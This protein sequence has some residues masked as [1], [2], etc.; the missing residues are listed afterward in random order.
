MLQHVPLLSS[1]REVL[2]FSGQVNR[3][4]RS[5]VSFSLAL[6]LFLSLKPVGIFPLTGRGGLREVLQHVPFVWSGSEA[7]EGLEI[8]GVLGV[9]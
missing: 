1:E 6:S 5:E 3:S 9:R 2:R 8:L 4:V 7:P